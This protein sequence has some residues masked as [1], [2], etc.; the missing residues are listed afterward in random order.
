[1]ASFAT[2]DYRVDFV[3]GI[4]LIMIFINHIPGNLLGQMTNR[5]F[6]FSDS[7]EVFVL[8]AGFAAAMAYYHRF[9]GGESFATS[10]RLYRRA[11]LLYTAHILSSVLALAL[12]SAAALVLVQPDI[13]KHNNIAPLI[14]D[15]VHGLVVLVTLTHQLGYFNILPLYI[16]LLCLLPFY[17]AL[18]I[19]GGWRYVLIV[20]LSV[21]LVAGLYSITLPSFPA[22]NTWF[23]NPLSW[24]LLFAVGFIWGV[25]VRRGSLI[26]YNRHVYWFSVAY[27]LIA[28]FAVRFHLWPL[29]PQTEVLGE[30]GGF[31]KTYLSPFRLLHVL[32]LAYVIAYSPV[33]Q[34]MKTI[35]AHNPITQMGQHALPVFCVGSL[36][37]MLF[38]IMREHL[39]GGLVLDTTSVA[40]GIAIQMALACFLSWQASLTA[41]KA[42]AASSGGRISTGAS[43]SSALS[44][45][46]AQPPELVQP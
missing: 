24:Q 16:V 19:A 17:M 32:A 44:A 18:Y 28:L 38:F 26:P 6:G 42:R 33:A 20:A 35:S 45:R 15:P 22:E 31:S 46:R 36:L 13:I 27:V 25:G 8:V 10:L 3:R 23:F 9:S 14:E 1:M 11:G 5:N 34:W 41:G 40:L 4:A 21:Y 30:L 12:F 37:S 39:G 7:A 29:V 2:R 43:V